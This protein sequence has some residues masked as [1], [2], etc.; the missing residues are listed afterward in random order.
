MGLVA[1]YYIISYQERLFDYMPFNNKQV[2]HS[3]T[4]HRLSIDILGSIVLS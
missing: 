3:V 1:N 4:V 2:K